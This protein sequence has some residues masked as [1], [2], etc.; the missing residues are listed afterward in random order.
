MLDVTQLL[1]AAVK[2]GGS[3]A[4]ADLLPLVYDE[5]LRLAPS[6]VASNKSGQALDSP[7]SPPPDCSRGGVGAVGGGPERPIL[8]RAVRVLERVADDMSSPGAVRD[9]ARGG[10]LQARNA[11][12]WQA[13]R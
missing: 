1:A 11:E 12:V 10:L 5:P 4:A 13:E 2:A 8:R 3:A 7:H 9:R 6:R